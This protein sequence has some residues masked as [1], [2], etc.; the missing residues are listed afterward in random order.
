MCDATK[1]GGEKEGGVE[2]A[3]KMNALYSFSDLF[4]LIAAALFPLSFSH[5]HKARI[6]SS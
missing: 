6:I 2:G 3:L 1:K 4:L 5:S